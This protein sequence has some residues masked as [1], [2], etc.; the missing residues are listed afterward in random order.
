MSIQINIQMI[1][2]VLNLIYLSL[3]KKLSTETRRTKWFENKND[4]LIYAL[5]RNDIINKSLGRNFIK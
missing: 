5:L 4:Q 3:K 2:I 1:S